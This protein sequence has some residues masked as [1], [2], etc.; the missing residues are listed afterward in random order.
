MNERVK[1]LREQSVN[2]RPYISSERAELLTAFYKSGVPTQVSIPVARGLALK[3]IME[4]KAIAIQDGEL[5]V[6]ERGPAPKATPTYPEL[7]CHTLNDFD[8]MSNRDR[9]RFDVD[10]QVR[11]VYTD[12]II[13]FWQGRT[14]RE[15][16]FASMSEK[17]MAAFHA[18]VFTEFM[19]QRAPGHTVSDNK[20][21]SRGFLDF[22]DDIRHEL[23]NLD[24]LNDPQAYDKKQQL[25]GFGHAIDAILILAQ[26]YSQLAAEL[27]AKEKDADR[28]KELL[29]I[30]AIC[31]HVP[32]YAPRSF[33]E[34]LQMY[35]FIHLGVITELNVWDSYSP[36]RLDQHLYPFYKREM[37]AGTITDETAK[38]LLACFWVKFNNQPAPPKVGITEAQSGTYTDFA[39]INAGGVNPE[40]GSDAVND[41][42]YLMLDVVEDMKLVQPSA[43]IQIS[44]KNP[45]RFLRRACEVIRC[46]FGQ[47]SVF[48]T[49]VIIREMLQDG[50]TMF[51]ARS[52]GAS[53]C[54]ETSAFGKESC[55]LTGYINWPKI[56]ELALNDGVDPLTGKQIGIKTGNAA[57]FG[58]IDDV[59]NAYKRQLKYFVDMK[60]EGNNIIERQYAGDMPAM[61]LSVLTSDCIK[62]GRNY[63]DGGP[64]YNTS[65]I[66]GVGIGTLTDAL[67]A[68]K[69][70]VFDHG[71]MTMEQLLAAMKDNFQCNPA[72]QAMLKQSPRYG[73]DDSYADT[74]TTELFNIYFDAVNGR[75]NTKG[76]KYRINLLPTTVH[77]YFG[78]MT[79][80][81]PNGRVAGLPV[82]DGISPSHGADVNG[83]TAV[84]KSAAKIDHARTGGTLLNMKFTPQVLQGEGLEKLLHLIRGY[85]RLDGHHI[86]FNVVTA[87]M[88]RDAQ[89][90]PNEHRNLIVRV[91]GY[92]DYFNDLGPDLQNEIIARTEQHGL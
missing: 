37:D 11:K 21:Y 89:K 5:I 23:R 79:G 74:I 83:P 55:I 25:E 30:S 36:G 32:A 76:G 12:T 14:M 40:D 4:H 13:P 61:T 52:G 39:L 86:Q 73:N 64:R 27:A 7:C 24:F 34:A 66:Q 67:A 56:L 20:I 9:T 46:G 22:Q 59:V 29:R 31:K 85:F 6:G 80:A 62:K 33:H 54:V 47:P 91:A 69:Y 87:Q 8:M 53:G 77:V 44:A 45:D 28:R 57:Q 19:E 71:K 60:I 18:G 3:Y 70:N 42:S 63:H 58:S 75:P 38:E 41:V 88:L 78:Q 90:N 48:N 51:D 92:S 17:W 81:L 49:D 65:Y 50:K 68:I 10:D 35:W 26:R 43:C 82:S 1:K 84:I 72:M 2:T 16:I 15:R